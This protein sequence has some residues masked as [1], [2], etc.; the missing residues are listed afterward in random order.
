MIFRCCMLVFAAFVPLLSHAGN[1]NLHVGARSAGM[2]HS[3]LGLS[4][5]WSTHHNQ[6]GLATLEHAGA[7]VYYENRFL[8]K[9]MNLSAA[10][11]A[12][13][14]RS[15]TF[16]VIYHSFGYSSFNESKTGISY[17]RK[18]SDKFSVGIG[19]NYHSIRFGDVYGKGSAITTEMG[20]QIKI[21]KELLI[22]AHIF[23]LNRA[24]ITNTPLEYIPTVMRF[25]MLYTVSGKIIL[26]G[27]AQKDIDR[28]LSIRAGAEYRP[29][30][31][32][33]I[34][35]GISSNPTLNSF[36]FGC[37]F[38]NLV[39]DIAASYHQTLGFSP[40][41]GLSYTFSGKNKKQQ[42]QQ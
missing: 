3:S 26:T 28:P 14:T 34:R 20:L 38:N 22:A 32:L 1:D 35:A 37:Y 2:A 13:P 9:E 7:S 36:G 19:L 31:I 10:T 25:G 8:L 21:T 39:L 15:G 27:E 4:D 6:A 16:G 12:L 30:D 41:V 24:K 23:N 33:A 11:F 17:G 18:L 42:P 29:G 5:C 40:Q